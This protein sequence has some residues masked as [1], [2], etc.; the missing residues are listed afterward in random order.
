MTIP[1]ASTRFINRFLN[2]YIAAKPIDLCLNKRGDGFTL[3]GGQTPPGSGGPNDILLHQNIKIQEA[4]NCKTRQEVLVFLKKY[5][6]DPLFLRSVTLC[7]LDYDNHKSWHW[8]RYPNH[9]CRLK[10]SDGIHDHLSIHEEIQ[11]VQERL[12]E[13]STPHE[14]FNKIG[15]IAGPIFDVLYAK[16][17]VPFLGIFP[18]IGIISMGLIQL[19]SGLVLS[20]L[21][22]PASYPPTAHFSTDCSIIAQR[23]YRYV[24]LGS[25]NT[26]A[27]IVYG[28]ASMTIFPIYACTTG[29]WCP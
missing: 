17:Q 12:D 22:G 7:H 15:R 8:S 11:F 28:V 27:G 2:V 21:F 10:D 23:S 14:I 25:F 5:A 3:D 18:A 4:G 16:T 26:L 24:L 19:I 13:E 9:I 1:F 29:K 6:Q 20:I